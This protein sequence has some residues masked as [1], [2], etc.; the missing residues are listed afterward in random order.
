MDGDFDTSWE[1]LLR[2]IVEIHQKDASKLSFEELYRTAYTLVIR[3]H[4][5]RLYES[6]KSEI[7]KHL[8]QVL[9]TQLIPKSK[10]KAKSKIKLPQ[11]TTGPSEQPPTSLLPK[12][13]VEPNIELLTTMLSVWNDHCLCMRMISD[14]LMYLDRVYSRE[15]KVPLIYDA[16]LSI[17]RDVIFNSSIEGEIY[18]TLLNILRK[19]RD[20]IP[21]DRLL[22]KA[23]VK[24]LEFL[25]DASLL[26]PSIYCNRFE[27][28]L[29]KDTEK[30]YDEAAENLLAG[31]HNASI[32]I[33]ITKSWLENEIERA[34]MYLLPSSL[35]RLKSGIERVL[36][37][38]R[39]EKVLKFPENGFKHW[40]E[41]DQY[42]DIHLAYQ[43][44]SLV[45]SQYEVFRDILKSLVIEKGSEINAHSK[46]ALQAAKQ[47]RSQ[48]STKSKKQISGNSSLNVNNDS[49]SPTA[50]AIQWVEMVLKL[51]DKFDKIIIQ[52]FDSHPVISADVD[53]SFSAFIN[54]NA[55]V[56]EYLS[57]FIDDNLKKSLKG[58][59][60]SEIEDVL[61]KGVV[62]FRFIADKDIF[63][64]Y[65]K[66]HLAKRLLN[67]KSLSDDIER[68]MIA[69]LKMEIGTSFTSKLEGMFR[70]MKI[71]KEM[72]ADYKEYR[73]SN[74]PM[75]KG[76]TVDASV[77]VLTSTFWPVSVVSSHIKCNY[78]PEIQS[79]K[80]EFER[81][82]L[83]R[84]T[85]RK[86]AWN[87]NLGTA[88][89][90]VRFQKRVHEINMPTLAMIILL[91]FTELSDN[92]GLTFEQLLEQT[93]ISAQDLTRHLQSLAVAPRT[94][95]LKKVPMSKD[96]KS[97][98]KFFFNNKFESSMT[99]FKVLAISSNNKVETDTE[100]KETLAKVDQARKYQTD[101]AIVRVMKARKTLEHAILVDEVTK[102]LNSRFKPDPALIKNRIDHLLEQ[103]YLERDLE[104]RSVYNY[105]A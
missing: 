58:K 93:N 98:D 56:S 11:N 18:I 32:Y 55:K 66:A 97:T 34:T 10:M 42:S 48:G 94:R 88:D 75:I 60:D 28:H 14:I 85:G 83:A 19:D 24:M 47:A 96:V 72:M 87:P 2:A 59:S 40:V 7:R 31:N 4:G 95:I 54:K 49:L 68:S 62:L 101:A 12:E 73:A 69:K 100:K 25:P 44:Y 3:K 8:G 39:F 20:G 6:V 46:A 41:T 70:D 80:E 53:D 102:Q 71:S 82:Y 9:I 29:F 92:N 37:T 52:S 104:K 35:E 81:F 22:V 105:L 57:L 64:S 5:R 26:G 38:N 63:E 16:G 36:I 30:Y 23:I 1:I 51:R 76:Q 99:R 21:A 65:Y 15:A 77:N 74:D 84:H 27:P 103:E 17:F 91:Q 45:T 86:L 50:I 67:S 43:L 61:G 33:S 90:K 13:S 78:P 89:V 79:A